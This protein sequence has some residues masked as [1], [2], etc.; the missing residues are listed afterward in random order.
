MISPMEPPVR[1]PVMILRNVILFPQAMIPLHIF[2]DRYRRMLQDVLEGG[3]VFALA[4][5]R[6]RGSQESAQR[7][8]GLGLVRACVTHT[9][10]SSHLVLQGLCRVVIT[11][12]VRYRPY[13]V[14]EIRPVTPESGSELAVTA[15]SARLL[16]LVR[17]RLSALPEGA[18]AEFLG[19][20]VTPEEARLATVEA[21]QKLLEHL[22]SVSDPEQVAD[23]ISA[24]LLPDPIDRQL[25]LETPDVEG[26]LRHLIRILSRQVR[27]QQTEDPTP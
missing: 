16:E 3:R 6:G 18:F 8:A 10:G 23:L 24:T 27:R 25:I 21:F 13:R 19:A 14:C 22:N 4:M 17:Q 26:R 11:R 12:T 9:D 20:T 7:V 15:L 1:V 2:E 5:Q